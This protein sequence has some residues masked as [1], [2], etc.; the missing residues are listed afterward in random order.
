MGYY[1]YD[2]DWERKRAAE[3]QM[4]VSATKAAREKRRK[5]KRLANKKAI[6]ARRKARKKGLMT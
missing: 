1:D 4:E 5:E 6:K 3:K 2:S